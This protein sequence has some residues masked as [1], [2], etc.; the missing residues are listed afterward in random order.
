MDAA[1]GACE[2]ADD[3]AAGRGNPVV[4]NLR[5]LENNTNE[6]VFDESFTLRQAE[7]DKMYCFWLASAD[8]AVE[9]NGRGEGNPGNYELGNFSVSWPAGT[10]PTP[11]GPTF[12]F[13]EV[14][15]TDGSI[16][17]DP[18]DG[19]LEVT[20]GATATYAV[21][22][23]EGTEAEVTLTA[24]PGVTVNPTSLTFPHTD[25]TSDTLIVVL[26]ATH[27]LDVENE[28]VTVTH[29]ADDF[30]DATLTVTSMDEDVTLTVGES[31]ITEGGAA[32][33]FNVYATLTNE[34]EADVPVAWSF[35][36]G[37][38]VAAD[39]TATNVAD[40]TITAGNMSD[41]VE[42]T[43]TANDDVE[44]EGDETVNA[45]ATTAGQPLHLVPDAVTI[46]DDDPD[47]TLTVTPSSLN[48]GDGATTLT[49]SAE[50][51]MAMP[52]VLNVLVS[53]PLGD[54]YTV[55]GEATG[56]TDQTVTVTIDTGNTQS[57]S[58]TVSV[59]PQQDDDSDNITF[60][61]TGPATGAQVGGAGKFYSIEAATVTITDDDSS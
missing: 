1:A 30:D 28:D 14:D 61:I 52:G 45:Q 15:T 34:Q 12:E 58:M 9:A 39:W 41:T 20:E 32:K 40:M 48:E 18:I 5:D 47:V 10:P 23:T 59:D 55:N 31:S 3:L 38:A 7:G 42:V 37:T 50:S 13:F 51:D 53:I 44:I 26:T 8:V 11:P 46:M 33:T 22:L 43:L 17:D 4:R 49:I 19:A 36:G 57:N 24:A 25:G 54:G 21:K 56:G 6:I 29:S 27:D 60:E 2:A 35:G 16:G